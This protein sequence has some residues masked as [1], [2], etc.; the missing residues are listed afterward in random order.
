MKLNIPGLHGGLSQQDPFLRMD[1]QLEEAHNCVC[2]LSKGLSFPRYPSRLLN[3]LP[4][5]APADRYEYIRTTDNKD[6]LL[7]I[8]KATNE[9]TMVDLSGTTPTIII[10]SSELGYLD[11][12]NVDIDKDL[13][14]RQMLDYTF[15]LNKTKV[16]QEKPVAQ[17]VPS[18]GV[19]SIGI[20]RIKQVIDTIKVK[21]SVS[22]TVNKD[23]G[24]LSK[25]STL[26]DYS[27][28]FVTMVS[29]QEAHTILIALFSDPP[30]HVQPMVLNSETLLVVRE[31]HVVH[32]GVGYRCIL[33]HNSSTSGT[34]P[35]VGA[36]WTNYWETSGSIEG[37]P[38]LPS[39]NY[40]DTSDIQ[41]GAV[42]CTVVSDDNYNDQATEGYT[43][44]YKGD[45]GL[46][47]PLLPVYVVQ[48][49]GIEDL[50]GNLIS[51]PLSG[52]LC[53]EVADHYYFRWDIPKQSYVEC[54][55]PQTHDS[56]DKTTMPVALVYNPSHPQHFHV[57][58]IEDYESQGRLVGDQ[59]SNP[60]PRFVG[61]TL[62]DMLFHRD[63][64][65]F[66][67]NDNIILSRSGDYFNF[68]ATTA[69]EVLDDDPIDVT[70]TSTRYNPL[71]RAESF[72]NKLFLFSEFNQ[73]VFHSGNSPLTPHTAAADVTTSYSMKKD[74]FPVVSGGSMFILRRSSSNL[75]LMEYFLREDSVTNT[76]ISVGKQVPNLVPKTTTEMIHLDSQGLVLLYE[77]NSSLMQVYIYSWHGNKL[78]QS[79]WV[80]WELPIKIQKAFATGGNLYFVGHKDN[81]TYTL[82]MV[83]DYNVEASPYLFAL[84]GTMEAVVSSSGTI[85]LP[86]G[87]PIYGT[88]TAD[89]RAIDKET[90]LPQNF[91][92][93]SNNTVLRFTDDT[94]PGTTIVIGFTI[95]ASIRLSQ[96][97]LRDDKGLPRNDI[98]L[99]V[100]TI[101][102]DYFGGLFN[103]K[104]S[105]NQQSTGIT[106]FIQPGWF[107]N[108]AIGDYAPART[109]GQTKVPIWR[110]SENCVIS[111]HN[112]DHMI[113]HLSNFTYNLEVTS[114]GT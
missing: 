20:A 99:T 110:P 68:Y 37:A 69:A 67:S 36:N 76:A 19:Q 103:V 78:V 30:A 53:F 94:A 113:T 21:F 100:D 96:V 5:S 3:I 95:G 33:S 93:E 92:F 87:L 75:E 61:N 102:L 71:F 46:S 72:G 31:A 14:I 79:A 13:V 101:Q 58:S 98:R 7:R 70:P 89:V 62:A 51:N 39:S 23:T 10:P 82:E 60:S 84:D 28:P 34:E 90:G 83:P 104:A 15:I 81:L 42:S 73:F 50:P 45:Y 27:T 108:M 41:Q 85:S 56:L 86:A 65:C 2:S 24:L 106:A 57:E 26:E 55:L 114:D 43:S 88:T 107:N 77:K 52:R 1:N 111:L 16:I 25:E 105:N 80:T 48:T 97:V 4:E 63:R 35:G 22:L 91:F 40:F 38:W 49:A 9:I 109:K 18:F 32:G 29:G 66:L 6:W 44:Y 12:P 59:I 64:L 11:I 47:S 8:N 17:A 54:A 74:I 112:T